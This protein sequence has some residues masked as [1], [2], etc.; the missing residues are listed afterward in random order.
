MRS[1]LLPGLLLIVDVIT[2]IG[3]A[4]IS[5]LIRF[6]GYITSH[7][8]YQM[9]DALPNNGKSPILLCFCPCIYIRA[10]GAMQVCVKWLLY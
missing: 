2:I 10:Y 8:L 7:Y 3:V 5:L 9:I 1:Y 6:D 4:L